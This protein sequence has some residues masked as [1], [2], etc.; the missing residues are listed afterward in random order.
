ERIRGYPV[1]TRQIEIAG[2]LYDVLGPGNYEELVDDPRVLERFSKDEFLPYWAE[3]WPVCALMAEFVAAWGPATPSKRLTI[4]ELGCGLGLSS[5]VAARLGHRAIASDYDEDALEFVRESARRMDQPIP[6]T[7]FID[8]RETCPDL[9]P[10]R[11]VAAEILYERRS[12]AP[13]AQFFARH[14]PPGAIGLICDAIRHT[15]DDF[16]AIAAEAGL[17]VQTIVLQ[18]RTEQPQKMPP[19]RLF[20]LRH[21]PDAKIATEQITLWTSPNR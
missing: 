5:L 17:V 4:L 11:I 9:R 3:F 14:L 18:P 2:Q 16:P 13:I 10:D 12:L 8:W 15:A 6:E 1:K 21:K 20:E 7:Q 19:A